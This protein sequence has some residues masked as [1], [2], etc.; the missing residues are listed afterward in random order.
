MPNEITN[1]APASTV[2]LRITVDG[3]VAEEELAALLHAAFVEGGFTDP[4][5]APTLFAP[6]AVRA[7]D[8]H[9][10]ARRR[11]GEA[12]GTGHPGSPGQRRS[13]NRP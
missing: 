12:A 6:A 1:P 5:M 11:H 4:A 3:D 13:A 9:H 10:R 2:S 8:A 7:R